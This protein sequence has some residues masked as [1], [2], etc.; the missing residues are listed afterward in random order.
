M[1]LNEKEQK[2]YNVIEKVVNNEITK[3]DTRQQ[4]G[5][6]GKQINRLIAVFNTEGNY[7]P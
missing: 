6:T 1:E 2:K 4:L 7:C 5:L 3:K